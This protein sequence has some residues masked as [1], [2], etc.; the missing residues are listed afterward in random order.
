MDPLGLLLA[1]VA[2]A[3]YPGGLL[4]ACLAL[5]TLRLSGMP[6][7][8]GL[9]SRGLAAMCAAGV[10][11]SM[12]TLPGAPAASLPPPGGATPNLIAAVVLLFVAGSLIAPE[13][14]SSRRRVAVALGGVSVLLLGFVA[15]S[16]SIETLSGAG[17][18]AATTARI[19][20]AIGVLAALPVIVQPHCP[21]GSATAR[22]TLVAATVE[23][24]LGTLIPTGLHFPATVLWVGGLVAAAAVYALLLRLGSAVAQRE[25][26]TLVALAAVCASAG[27]LAAIIATR[28]S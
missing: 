16:F 21:G 19:V 28:G 10:A 6:R 17:G 25:H 22:A 9:D 8:T 24:V 14:W 27:S 23:V 1:I 20:V 15:A 11:A 12:A 7:S 5:L 26:I 3:V 4:L 18:G 13:P 2:L